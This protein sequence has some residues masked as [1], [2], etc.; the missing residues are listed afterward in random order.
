MQCRRNNKQ[1][2]ENPERNRAHATIQTVSTVNRTRENIVKCTNKV[3]KICLERT[4][5]TRTGIGGFVTCGLGKA[6]RVG[7]SA[8]KFVRADIEGSR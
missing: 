4:H 8:S 3:D 2:P 1:W 5:T 7:Q 6:D